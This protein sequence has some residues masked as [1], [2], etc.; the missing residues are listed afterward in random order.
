MFSA[1]YTFELKKISC[2]KI[3]LLG[4]WSGSWFQKKKSVKSILDILC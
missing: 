1:G 2:H 4:S 3:E